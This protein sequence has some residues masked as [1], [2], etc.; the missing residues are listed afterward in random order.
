MFTGLIEDVGTVVRADRRSDALVLGIR[1]AAFPA[2]ELS[3][4]ESGCHDGA[5]LTL[6]DIAGDT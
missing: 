3:R 1:P 4:G 6:T 5:S 2:S